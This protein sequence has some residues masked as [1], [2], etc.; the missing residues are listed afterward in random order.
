MCNKNTIRCFTP[1]VIWK[2]Q[3]NCEIKLENTIKSL[4]PLGWLSKTQEGKSMQWNVDPM[5]V[6][7]WNNV[8]IRRNSCLCSQTIKHMYKV[9]V[10]ILL[11]LLPSDVLHISWEWNF[12]ITCHLYLIF[13]WKEFVVMKEFWWGKCN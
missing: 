5:L 11:E 10:G 12:R 2:I 6:G 9:P 4:Q 13:K 3:L 1:L 8:T 7:M